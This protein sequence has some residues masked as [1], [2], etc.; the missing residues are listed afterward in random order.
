MNFNNSLVELGTGLPSTKGFTKLYL[1]QSP[2]D[3]GTFLGNVVLAPSVPRWLGP[4]FPQALAAHNDPNR[5][6][7]ADL[8][9][10]SH[11]W[12]EKIVYI[13][14]G[15]MANVGSALDPMILAEKLISHSL[16]TG[17][18]T[19][20]AQVRIQRALFDS[21]SGQLSAVDDQNDNQAYYA[22]VWDHYTDPTTGVTDPTQM[23]TIVV[24][25]LANAPSFVEHSRHTERLA[26]CYI[27]RNQAVL[28]QV[29]PTGR[30]SLFNSIKASTHAP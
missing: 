20:A 26:E 6:K 17:C 21:D 14:N 19:V 11:D 30:A 23:A 27:L 4:Y 28:D 24:A 15:D 29:I 2:D 22:I 12:F 8:N 10:Y 1:R 5:S 25:T 13:N 16:S 18:H 7:S 3:P 9:L